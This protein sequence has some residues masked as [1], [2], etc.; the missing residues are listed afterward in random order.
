LLKNLALAGNTTTTIITVGIGIDVSVAELNR[1]ASSPGNS[2]LIT[3]F[4]NGTLPS[5]DQQII[6]TVFGKKPNSSV[7][8]ITIIFAQNSLPLKLSI[9]DITPK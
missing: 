5:P 1:L 6:N 9:K 7:L 3:N 4:V 2:I 8:F